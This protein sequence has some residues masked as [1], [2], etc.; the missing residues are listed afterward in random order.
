[1]DRNALRS[2]AG[3]A[4]ALL[5]APALLPAQAHH[6]SSTRAS[7]GGGRMRVHYIAADEVDWTYVPARG[8]LALTGKKDDFAS[9]PV[10]RGALDPNGSTYRKAL[11]REYT[12][13]TFR[14]LLPRDERYAHMGLLGPL[15]RAEVGDTIRVVFRNHATRPYSM[16]PH[17]VFYHK[18][19][20]GMAY[21]DGTSGADRMD[22]SV[23]PGRT[24]VYTWPVPER[25]GP[26]EGDG[27]TAFWVY[28]S[29]VDEGKDINAGL[30]GPIIVTRRGMARPDG[31]S[32]EFDREFVADF[33]FFDETESWY[34]DSNVVKIYGDPKKF[35]IRN[36]SQREFHHFFTVNGY[37]EGNG[38]VFTMRQGDR[39]RWYLFTNPNENTG[40]DIHTPHWHGQTVVTNH[41]RAD[42]VPDNPGMWLFHC[43][44]NGHFPGG[45]YA[46]F[47]VLPAVVRQP[48]TR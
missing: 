18:D 17:G 38:P 3:L 37:L 47:E 1:M 13:S 32:K 42:M 16:H 8:D 45:M 34:L 14:T 9:N 44:M 12:D 23:P 10:A 11:F 21:L 46:R 31:S 36:E 41:M 35:D 43:H 24:H 26:A 7:P 15:L 39:V 40:W 2:L 30:I 29:H 28:H 33:G 27:S 6:A 22:D 4:G 20:E 5:F 48:A 25:A 19:S